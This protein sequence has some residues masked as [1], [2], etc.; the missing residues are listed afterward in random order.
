MR[1]RRMSRTTATGFWRRIVSNPVG[2][3][4]ASR[5]RDRQ[6]RDRRS[7]DRG[8]TVVLDDDDSAQ[9]QSSRSSDGL[10]SADPGVPVGTV[11]PNVL[12]TP[13]SVSSHMLATHEA[14]DAPTQRQTEP[15]ALLRRSA[16]RPLLER[17][18][19]A[20]TVL[21]S[22]ADAGIGHGDPEVAVLGPCTDADLAAVRS[23]LHRVAQQVEQNLLESQFVG[24]GEPDRRVDVE[25]ESEGMLARRARESSRARTRVRH[26][27]R[28]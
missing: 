10:P 28:R 15:R 12:P 16:A 4:C 3:S 7:A 5:P 22:D 26:G 6:F 8:R 21:G 23:E 27:R 20:L 1:G 18:E 2:P 11:N 24:L 25:R 9:V 13:T 19:D 14:D 17:L